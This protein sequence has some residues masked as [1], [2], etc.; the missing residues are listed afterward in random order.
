MFYKMMPFSLNSE[1]LEHLNSIQYMPYVNAPFELVAKVFSDLKS[2]EERG[3][4]TC[5]GRSQE[6]L[7]AAAA[8]ELH[9]ICKMQQVCKWLK[10]MI[11]TI[12]ML[13]TS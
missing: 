8:G 9:R 10:V 3:V 11:M 13:I 1:I 7:A 5:Q 12:V 4:E 6:N 2:S